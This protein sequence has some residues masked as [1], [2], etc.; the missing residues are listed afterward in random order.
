[1]APNPQGFRDELL[2]ALVVHSSGEDQPLAVLWNYA[3]HPVAGPTQNAVSGHFPT[4]VRDGVRQYYNNS[5]LPVL[6]F[7]GFSGN[8]RPK[9]SGQAQ[10]LKSKVRRRLA[11]PVFERMKPHTYQK[12]MTSLT[13]VLLGAIRNA[14]ILDSPKT[15]VRRISIPGSDFMDANKPLDHVYVSRIDLDTK[16]SFVTVSAEV[17]AEYAPILRQI[18]H[19]RHVVCVGCADHVIGYLPTQEIMS[20]GGYEAGQFCKPFDL[21]GV[22]PKAPSALIRAFEQLA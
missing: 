1:M 5:S 4:A 17:V 8:T 12:W 19:D 10:T 2:T 16:V 9:A 15:S 7:Q 3:C 21:D 14:K 18:L 20:E 13:E 22:N 6:F 11:G